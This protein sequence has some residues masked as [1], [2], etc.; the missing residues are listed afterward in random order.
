MANDFKREEIV[1]ILKR[2]QRIDKKYELFGTSKHKYKLN[3]TISVSFVREVEA[4]Y[5]FTL[6]EDYFRFITEVGDGGAGPDYGIEPFADFLKTVASSGAERFREAYRESLA[7]PFEPREMQANEVEDFAFNRRAYEQNPNDFFVY[8]K[9]DENALCDTDGFLVIGTQ[10]CQ[11]DFGLVVTGTRRGSVF[12]MDNEGAYAYVAGSFS[13]FY[14]EWL[15][16]I[17]DTKKL[18]EKLDERR[19]LFARR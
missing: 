4:K 12:V 16:S 5:G 14:R 2:A 3:P 11:W 17:S 1:E 6:P 13:E 9:L 7:N 8:E 15:N 10:G 19:R 18:Q